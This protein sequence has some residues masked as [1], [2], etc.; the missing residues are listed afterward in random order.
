MNS[1]PLQN[2]LSSSLIQIVVNMLQFNSLAFRFSFAWP[3][4]LNSF[5]LVQEQSAYIGST[6]F[7]TQCLLGFSDF[8]FFYLTTICI[9]I[10]PIILVACT[11]LV[12]YVR[13]RYHLIYWRSDD[14]PN[15]ERQAYERC[16]AAIYVLLFFIHPN[17]VQQVFSLVNCATVG[18]LPSDNNLYSDMSRQCWDTNHYFYVIVIGLP[19]CIIYVIGIPLSAFY[20][21]YRNSDNLSSSEAVPFQ[22]L[23]VKF[24]PEYWYWGFFYILRQVLMIT[25]TTF[26][27]D[28]QEQALCAIFLCFLSIFSF[29][30][31]KYFSYM[32]S[33]TLPS[34]LF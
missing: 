4:P 16:V 7:S 2:N 28:V 19:M 13:F 21:L 8:S 23:F 3:D 9:A 17:I 24:E 11:I 22:F 26:V 10:A 20:I 29:L 6:M 32:Y 18:N 30:L 34:I 1:E 27:R 33:H 12:F 25:I 15:L 14:I 5:L 31:Q